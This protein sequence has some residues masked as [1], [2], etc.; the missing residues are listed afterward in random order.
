MRGRARLGG[1]LATFSSFPVLHMEEEGG[2][3]APG[4]DLLES[5]RTPPQQV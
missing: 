5:V 3:L 2:K 4:A 1:L